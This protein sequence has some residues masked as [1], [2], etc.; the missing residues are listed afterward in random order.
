MVKKF[1][2]TPGMILYL[3]GF[4]GLVVCLAEGPGEIGSKVPLALFFLFILAL[5]IFIDFKMNDLPDE[6]G[7]M[8]GNGGFG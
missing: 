8:E 2:F 6:F 4:I 7:E 1:R 3:L 5:G